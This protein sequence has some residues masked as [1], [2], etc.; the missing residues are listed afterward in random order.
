MASKLDA[1]CLFL[2][3]LWQA[4]PDFS[5]VRVVDGPQVNEEDANEWLFVGYDADN[6]DDSTEGASAEQDWMAFAKLK[7]EQGEVTCAA[8]V[9]SGEVNI[10][11]VR[12]RALDIV[13]DAEDG[14]RTDPTLG[15]LV[16]QSWLS[17]QRFIPM[18]TQTGCKARVVFTVSYLAQL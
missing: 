16:M 7:Q 8:V 11:A 17:D 10:P 13:S 1:V 15:G 2:A 3:A 9:R 6:L 18:V 12:A 4:D 5:T 14:L